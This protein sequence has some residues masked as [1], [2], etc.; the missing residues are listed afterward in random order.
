MAEVE[1]LLLTQADCAF[2]ED[3]K[4]LVDTLARDYPLAVRTVELETEE[5]RSLAARGGILFPPGVFVD[6]EPFSYGRPSERKLRKALERRLT[7]S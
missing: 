1:L 6:G 3:A 7:S 5:G 4:G 2:C